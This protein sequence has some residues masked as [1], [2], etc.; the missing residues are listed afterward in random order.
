MINIYLD[1]FLNLSQNILIFEKYYVEIFQNIICIVNN[2]EYFNSEYENYK[3]ILFLIQDQ[4]YWKR[5][6]LIILYK[7]E[8]Q[9]IV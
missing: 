7:V 5:V 4:V 6:I 3:T 2:W 9:F 1:F 8:E